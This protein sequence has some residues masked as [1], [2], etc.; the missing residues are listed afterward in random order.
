[1]HRRYGDSPGKK[2]L[3]IL[4]EKGLRERELNTQRKLLRV[5][6]KDL[7]IRTRAIIRR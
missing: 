1:M 3:A 2:P 6:L 5:P 7:P 4:D